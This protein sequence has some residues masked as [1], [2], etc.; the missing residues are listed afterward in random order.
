[1]PDGDGDDEGAAV[2]V[3]MPD[4]AGEWLATIPFRDILPCEW[5]S[6]ELPHRAANLFT[7]CSM[8][9]LRKAVS[10]LESSSSTKLLQLLP[11]LLL[12]PLQ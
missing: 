3:D 7:E 2:P 9:A 10:T 12:R 5:P 8:V 1:M 11:R 4:A 6:M